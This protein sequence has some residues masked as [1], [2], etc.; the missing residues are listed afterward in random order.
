[1]KIP[2]S[3]LV[4]GKAVIFKKHYFIGGFDL[5][6]VADPHYFRFLIFKFLFFGGFDENPF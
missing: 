4:S 6:L 3:L 2:F 5:F 1:M